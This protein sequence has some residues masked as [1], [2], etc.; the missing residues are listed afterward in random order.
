M[1]RLRPGFKSGMVVTKQ[2]VEKTVARMANI[3]DRTV[4]GRE[5]DRLATLRQDIKTR[6]V[7]QDEAIDSVVRS[8]LR[9]RAGLKPETRPTGSF[10]FYGPT[11][12][13]KTELAKQLANLMGV[14]FIR[15]DMSE[16]V[17]KHSIAR[18]IGAPPGYV[19]FDQGGLLTEAL[20]RTPHALV[21]LDEIEKA[22]PDIFNVL[23]QIMDYATLTDNSG[24]KADFRHAILIMTSNAGARDMAS[25]P[26]GFMD[27]ADH[28]SAGRALKAVENIFSPEFRNRLDAMVPFHNLTPA[29]MENIVRLA[30]DQLNEGLGPRRIQLE[31]S[32]DAI[33]WLSLHGF[34]KKLGA[35][36]LQRLLRESLE[37][38]LS[39]QVLFGQLGKGGK[40]IVDAPPEGA[41]EMRL[42]VTG[43]A[44]TRV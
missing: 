35:R 4:A 26:M 32:R 43:K 5:R 23:L 36:P 24:R 22:H 3:P 25:T 11:G 31:L 41:R 15:F 18:L 17:E 8:I 42:K 7:G 30:V 34:D 6:I 10:L 37:D 16:Y 44:L 13:G 28:D 20:R 29:N 2:D 33:N 27:G 9:A 12:V 40:V 21:L 39:E 38:P 1:V 14:A 19:G